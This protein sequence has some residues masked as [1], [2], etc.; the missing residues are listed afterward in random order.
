MDKPWTNLEKQE[1]VQLVKAVSDGLREPLR[2]DMANDEI[3]V[4]KDSI[5][6]LKHHGSY[7]QQNRELKKKADR[8]KS[9]Q[10]MLRLKVPCGEVPPAMFRELDDLSKKW[11][12]GDL[13]ATTR[14]AFQL[15][16]VIK[17]NLKKVISS[18]AN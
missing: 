8:D 15:H 6:I 12:Q 9:Y 10:F 17:G 7:M 3:F 2:A 1:D 5:H 16:G 18:I 14:Q 4:S 13:R 11:G